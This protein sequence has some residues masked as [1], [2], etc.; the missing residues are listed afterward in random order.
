MMSKLSLRRILY[1]SLLS[2]I[3]HQSAVMKSIKKSMSK[4]ILLRRLLGESL[5]IKTLLTVI[6]QYVKRTWQCNEA[7]KA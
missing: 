3:T 1:Y 6:Y 5:I 7:S 2:M 4:P